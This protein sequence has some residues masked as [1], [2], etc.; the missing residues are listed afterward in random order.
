MG[1][2][3]EGL[4]ADD[5]DCSEKQYCYEVSRQCV[6]YTL[7]SR[8]NRR[9]NK[10]P[11]QNPRQ[12]GPCLPGYTAEELGT[13]ELAHLCKKIIPLDTVPGSDRLNNTGII[14]WSVVSV[15]FFIVMTVLCAI[16]WKRRGRK[17]QNNNSELCGDLE[18]MQPSAPPE[19][20]PFINRK[21]GLL[22]MPFSK[23]LKDKNRLVHTSVFKPPC[24]VTN[25]PNY[26]NNL[27][28]NHD[29]MNALQLHS[30]FRRSSVN[31]NSNALAPAQL[32][33]GEITE[34]GIE[35]IENSSNAALVQ[36]NES[37][38]NASGDGTANNNNNSNNNSNNNDNGSG[39]A[40]TS[41]S[42]TRDGRE[43]ARSSNILIAQIN[44]NVHNRDY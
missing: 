6:N 28:N 5:S 2:I 34:Y 22:H 38:S 35:Q 3:E 41:D 17:R 21:K 26:E 37:S 20:S 23:I 4:C 36:R 24:Y 30:T 39:N 1:T 10:K 14:C 8:Y 9:E 7:C 12:C 33:Q 27:N 16:F 13:G 11:A 42:N 25:D 32:V 43:R 18:T 15:I 31:D 44:V 19:S 29:G 40:S